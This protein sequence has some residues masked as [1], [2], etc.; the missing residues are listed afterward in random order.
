MTLINYLTRVHFADGILEEAL[1]G[2]MSE[3]GG[4][5]PL[6]VI[7]KQRR[8]DETLERLLGALPT[9]TEAAIFRECPIAPDEALIRRVVK[10]YRAAGH[11]AIVAFGDRTAINFAKIMRLAVADDRPL[12]ELARMGER[13]LATPPPPLIALPTISG[14]GAALSAYASAQIAADRRALLSSR[15]LIPSVAICDPTLTLEAD[16]HES[17]S[18]GVEAL[19]A[20]AEAFLAQGYNP[21]AE[22][23]ALDGLRRAVRSLHGAMKGALADRRELSAAGLNGSLA[24]Q[25]GPGVAYAVVNALAA[26]SRAGPDVGAVSRLVLPG[27]LRILPQGSGQ[28]G[29]RVRD[30]LGLGDSEDL[31]EGVR[32]F[33]APL[34]LPASLSIMGVTR[35]DVAAAAD[36]AA[37]DLALTRNATAV[38]AED[39]T[40]L[41]DAVF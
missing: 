40:A 21:P 6:V 13:K 34:P 11:D 7:S 39:L 14:Y 10:D 17:A 24:Q 28:Q 18:A 12:A 33:L 31:S 19:A 20:C 37:R 4:R 29:A 36:E 41:M 35:A 30:I 9:R 25:K 23:I 1:W 27:V 15:H 32:R 16:E 2:E 8:G 38:R 5:R 26:I 3:I 22:G